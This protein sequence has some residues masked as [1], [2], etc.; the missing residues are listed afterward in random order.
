MQ[1]ST[2]RDK[3]YETVVIMEFVAKRMCY[4]FTHTY[5]REYIRIGRKKMAVIIF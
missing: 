1:K 3:K 2:E 5:T 4:T